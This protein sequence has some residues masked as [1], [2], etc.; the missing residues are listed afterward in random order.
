MPNF[1]VI[2][3]DDLGYGDIGPYGSTANST[4][5]L[6]R[7]AQDGVKLTD[8]YMAS[9]VCSPSRAALM[10]GCYPKRIGLDAG[11]ES[12]ESGETSAVLNPGDQLGLSP[13][14]TTIASLLGSGGYRTKMI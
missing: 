5:H 11:Q 13:D 12:P 8:F 9:P 7:M 2:L 10:T 4:P 3:C 14:E 1:V 6:D